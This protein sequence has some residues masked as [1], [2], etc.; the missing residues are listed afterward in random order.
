MT[1]YINEMTKKELRELPNQKPTDLFDSIVIVPM[2]YL[3][4]S[5]YRCM[6]YILLRDFEIVGVVGGGSDVVHIN[7]INGFGGSY[8]FTKP[9][10]GYTWRI[11]CL[12]KS[13]CVRLFSD[14][15][16]ECDNYVGT[17]DFMFYV[18]ENAREEAK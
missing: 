13:Q 7:G 8:E 4:D 12:P 18:K 11:D 16:C 14:E 3:H 5:G 17:S 15:L 6:K 1:E 10:K 2:D 9:R